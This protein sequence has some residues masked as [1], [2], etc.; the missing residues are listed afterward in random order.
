MEDLKNIVA[1]IKDEKLKPNYDE[2]SMD[3][4]YVDQQETLRLKEKKLSSLNNTKYSHTGRPL[5][6][7]PKMIGAKR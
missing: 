3:L 4:A 7:S 5:D 1:G 6:N 2:N